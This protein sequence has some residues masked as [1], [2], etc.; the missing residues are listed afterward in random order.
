MLR[1]IAGRWGNAFLG[2]VISASPEQAKRLIDDGSAVPADRQ[3]EAAF[4]RRLRLM[5]RSVA[6]IRGSQVLR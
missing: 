1:T 6:G 5:P 3:M 2:D 4:E